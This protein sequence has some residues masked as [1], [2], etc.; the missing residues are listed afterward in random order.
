[1]KKFF[2]YIYYF[3][4]TEEHRGGDK[5]YEECLDLARGLIKKLELDLV[6]N[7]LQ[8]LHAMT[9]KNLSLTSKERRIR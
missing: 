7:K 4:F 3:P 6:K 9:F 8:S 5:G 2:V 1:V